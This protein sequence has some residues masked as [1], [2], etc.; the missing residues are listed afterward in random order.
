MKGR[1]SGM[2]AEDYWET[3]YDADCIVVKLECA[4]SGSE[5]VAEFG[6]GYGTFTLPAAKRTSGTIYAFD[7]EADLVESL[8]AKSAR[9]GLPNVRPALRDFVADGTGLA[10]GS[11]DHVMVYNLLHIEEP[12]K[13]PFPS[14][15]GNTIHPHPEAL[16]W[17]SD[18]NLNNAARGLSQ[19]V[20]FS[21]AI[22]IS[23]N[24]AIIITE[25]C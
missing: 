13:G 20:S 22:K 19:S 3:F 1:E 12:V 14:F 25:C 24:A 18:Q 15:I 7:I 9:L 5:T 23:R 6:S 10:S 2:P 17:T 4:K 21:S 16:R 8:R 11:V